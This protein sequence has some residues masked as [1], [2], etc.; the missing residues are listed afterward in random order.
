MLEIM[1]QSA[2]AEGGVEAF[3]GCVTELANYEDSRRR[4]RMLQLVSGAHGENW[5]PIFA[6]HVVVAD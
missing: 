1:T 2:R 6:T 5:A 3:L 4:L